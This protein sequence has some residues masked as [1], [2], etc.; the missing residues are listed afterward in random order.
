[1]PKDLISQEI[2]TMMHQSQGIWKGLC[3]LCQKKPYP[4]P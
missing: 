4:R 1:M 3:Q 2:L